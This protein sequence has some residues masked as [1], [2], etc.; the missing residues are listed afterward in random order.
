MNDYEIY[1]F[2]VYVGFLCQAN[3][4]GGDETTGPKH[5]TRRN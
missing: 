3:G 4:D 1:T 2:K 5:T